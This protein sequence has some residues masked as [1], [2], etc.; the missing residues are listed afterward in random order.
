MPEKMED[1]YENRQGFRSS[2]L[3]VFAIMTGIWLLLGIFL[4]KGILLFGLY[5]LFVSLLTYYLLLPNKKG[6]YKSSKAI[7]NWQIYYN[8]IFRDKKTYKPM[9]LEEE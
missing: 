6:R 5:L 3:R 7:R 8:Y 9:N 2:D 1:E 4:V